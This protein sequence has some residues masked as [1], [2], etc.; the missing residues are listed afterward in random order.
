MGQKIKTNK[1]IDNLNSNFL[2]VIFNYNNKFREILLIIINKC[3]TITMVI[4]VLPII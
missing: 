3:M 2:F 4:I 1:Y